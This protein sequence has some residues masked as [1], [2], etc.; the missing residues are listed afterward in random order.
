MAMEYCRQKASLGG[1]FSKNLAMIFREYLGILILPASPAVS[2]IYTKPN[3][4][5]SL[6]S[7]SSKSPSIP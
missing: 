1:A 4:R 2:S 6:P 3:Y 7:S 5:K